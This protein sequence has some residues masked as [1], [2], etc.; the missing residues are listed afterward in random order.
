LE[1]IGGRSGERAEKMT[2][3]GFILGVILDMNNHVLFGDK[4]LRL[5]ESMLL[6]GYPK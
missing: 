4:Y 6:V 3:L 1:E 2:K 5:V